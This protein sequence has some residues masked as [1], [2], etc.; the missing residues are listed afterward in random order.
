M[1]ACRVWTRLS[2]SPSLSGSAPPF[3]AAIPSG[4]V[5]RSEGG[6]CQKPAVV[7]RWSQ[8]EALP[9]S[10]SYA[11]AR[12]RLSI[13]VPYHSLPHTTSLGQPR[14]SYSTWTTRR[15]PP[16]FDRSQ[17]HCYSTRRG[18]LSS[19]E[20]AKKFLAALSI[21]QRTCLEKAVMEGEAGPEVVT[22]PT[23]NQLKLCE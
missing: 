2:I 21:P 19:M 17:S 13:Q 11:C 7:P 5:D 14:Y 6:V 23:W 22:P 16:Q 12:A 3:S 15:K 4:R 20:D 1:T 8:E 18:K 9:A 10:Y